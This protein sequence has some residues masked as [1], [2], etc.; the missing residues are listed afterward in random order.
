M[1]YEFHP[2]AVKEFEKAVEYYDSCRAGLGLEF[3]DEVEH[4]LQRIETF[5]EAWPSLS[6]NTRR[7]R[8]KRFPFGVVYQIL[9]DRLI[10]IAVMNLQQKPNYWANRL[11]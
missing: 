8:L 7:C 10:V 6:K 4:T 1:N 11:Q 3:I 9:Q 5:P 2:E